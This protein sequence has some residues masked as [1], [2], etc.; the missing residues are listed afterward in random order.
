MCAGVFRLR[1]LRMRLAEAYRPAAGLS[2]HHPFSRAQKR[3]NRSMPFSM[4]AMLHA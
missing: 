4:V 2:N 1:P 3:A